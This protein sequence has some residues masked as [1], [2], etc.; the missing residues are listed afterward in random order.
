M[1]LFA[2]VCSLFSMVAC[3]IASLLGALLFD[4]THDLAALL[5][6]ASFGALAVLSFAHLVK[7]LDARTDKAVACF[8]AFDRERQ[9]MRSRN[10]H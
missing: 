6:F 10:R 9:R 2:A 7:L 4:A 3:A 1:N 5:V 8:I